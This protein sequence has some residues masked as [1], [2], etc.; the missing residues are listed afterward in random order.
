LRTWAFYALLACFAWGT[1]PIAVKLLLP[2]MTPMAI[3]FHRFLIASLILAVLL[4]LTGRARTIRAALSGRGLIHYAVLSLL[5]ALAFT[6]LF[7]IGVQ[8][9]TA[10]KAS[11]LVSANP[12][13]TVVLAHIFL[14][15]RTNARMISWTLLGFLGVFLVLIGDL[16]TL[17]GGNF[18]GD[19]LSL[20][21]G[22]S[23]AAFSVA[24][25]NWTRNHEPSV[26]TSLVIFLGVVLMSPLNL[27]TSSL[28]LPLSAYE[29]TLLL[30]LGAF[31]AAAAYLLWIKALT[32][33]GASS[34]GSFQFTVPLVT[35]LLDTAILG[36]AIDTWTVAG[37]LFVAASIYQTLR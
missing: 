26:S 16:Q 24:G 21:A 35:M 18:L 34:V 37:F 6:A 5:G 33:A 10:G 7:F 28:E 15:E 32:L 12:I 29:L 27:V 20:G 14:G 2:F 1:T 23:W 4:I 9:T 22:V 36:E 30:Y 13:I 8:F 25:K 11:L 3:A 31:T 19:L 17:L